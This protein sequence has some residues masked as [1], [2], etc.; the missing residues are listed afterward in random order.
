MSS[1]DNL[2]KQF[3]PRLGSRWQQC[4]TINV[5]WLVGPQYVIVVFPD[6]THALFNDGILKEMFEKNNYNQNY[7]DK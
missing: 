6:H 3:G 5:R 4:S 2:C 7:H 1:A